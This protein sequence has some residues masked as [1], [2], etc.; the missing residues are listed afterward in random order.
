M[1][2]KA[3]VVAA[4]ALLSS[5]LT[6]CRS[7]GEGGGDASQPRTDAVVQVKGIDT[8]SLTARER[9]DWSESVSHLLSP[10]ADQAVSLAQCVNE[11]RPC[12][13]CLPAV[14]LLLKEVQRGRTQT[15]IEA[16]YRERFSA[17]RIKNIDLADTPSKGPANAPIVVVEFA[18]FECPA[19]GATQPVLDEL[20]EHHQGQIRFFYKHYPLPMHPNAEKAA[21]AAVAAMRQGKFWE[22]HAVLFKNQQALGV[23]NVEK[24]AQGIG[25]D[26][27]K[28]RQDRDAEATADFVAKNRKQ[29]EAL[30]LT[31]TPSI[32]INGRKFSST[33]E[34]QAQDFEDWV[35]LELELTGASAP[36]AA[37][38]ASAAP[39]APASA[40]AA[41]A[42]SAPRPAGST[43]KAP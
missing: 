32:F 43:A 24:L 3:L 12:R 30:E 39:A 17:D 34:N 10:C 27:V 14:R 15:Q 11:N 22:M 31:G 5:R 40:A 16:S 23:E 20:Y 29:G 26:M 7:P 41:P 6:T 8:S 18:D 1:S 13:G 4:V 35:T 21:R 33:G 28:F 42:A 9:S 37:A 19:C 38:P 36:A 2:M 25:L